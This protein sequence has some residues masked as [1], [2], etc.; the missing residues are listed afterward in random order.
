MTTNSRAREQRR[1]ALLKQLKR[2][3]NTQHLEK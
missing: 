1:K 3:V 2:A